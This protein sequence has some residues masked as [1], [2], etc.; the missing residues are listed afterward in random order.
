MEKCRWLEPIVKVEV[1]FVQWTA[2]IKAKV[3]G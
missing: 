3:P 1:A 2:A